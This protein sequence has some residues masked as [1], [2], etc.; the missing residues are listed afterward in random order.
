[1]LAA[2]KRMIVLNFGHVIA[3]DLSDNV[4]NNNEVIECYLGGD[5]KEYY[6]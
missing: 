1:M 3:D 4:V 5:E 6:A 2:S